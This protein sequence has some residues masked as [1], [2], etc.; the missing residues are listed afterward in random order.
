MYKTEVNLL[1]KICKTD[2]FNKLNSKLDNLID[3]NIIFNEY[4]D[5]LMI[6]R[7]SL[8]LNEPRINQFKYNQFYYG[9]VNLRQQLFSQFQLNTINQ[10]I[11]IS[12][13]LVQPYS[14]KGTYELVKDLDSELEAQ[15]YFLDNTEYSFLDVIVFSSLQKCRIWPKLY[16]DGKKSKKELPQLIDWYKVFMNTYKHEI[17]YQFDPNI[18]T[19]KYQKRLEI[20]KKEKRLDKKLIEA[21]QS[22]QYELIQSL[23][24]EGSDIESIEQQMYKKPAHIACELGDIEL[25]RFIDQFGCDWESLDNEEQTPIFY[26]VTSGNLEVVKFLIEEKKVNHQHKEFQDRTPFYLACFLG[27]MPI[28]EYLYEKG[29]NIN[30]PSKLKRCALSKACYLGHVEVVKFLV[31]KPETD[32]TMQDSKGR[33]GMHNAAWGIEGGKEGKRRGTLKLPDSPQSIEVL[34]DYGHPIDFQDFEG[35]TPLLSAA[36]SDARESLRV[37]IN[38]GANKNIR[39]FYGETPVFLAAKYGHTEI[40][41]TLIDE[42]NCDWEMRDIRNTTPCEIAAINQKYECFDILLN[43]EIQNNTVNVESFIKKI[44]DEYITHEEQVKI[45]ELYHSKVN[46]KDH[47]QDMENVISFLTYCTNPQ[48]MLRIQEIILDRLN[49]SHI[50]QFFINLVDNSKYE[51]AFQILETFQ[52]NHKSSDK[53]NSE[54]LF[55]PQEIYNFIVKGVNAS[56]EIIS[57]LLFKVN[58]D[59]INFTDDLTKNSFLHVFCEQRRMKIIVD[60]ITIIKEKSINPVYSFTSNIYLLNNTLF[61]TQDFV[62]KYLN[63]VNSQ[64]LNSLDICLLSKA[65]DIHLIIDNFIRSFLHEEPSY[66]YAIPNYDFEMISQRDTDHALISE[67]EE[68]AKKLQELIK[69]K[70][71]DLQYLNYYSFLDDLSVIDQQK[72]TVEDTSEQSQ[73][74]EKLYPNRK[75][76]FI[77]QMDSEELRI[78]K[79]EVEKNSIF[80]ID[81]EYYTENKDKNLG[82]VCTIQISTVNMDFMIDA[83]AL[84]SQLNELLNKSL[85]LN[86]NKI[87][88]LHGCENDIK[89][90]KNDFDIDIVNLFDTMFAEMIIKNKQQSYSLKNLSQD[91][92][93]VELDKSYQISDWRIRPLPIPMMNYARVD[94]FILLRLFPIMKEMLVSKNLLNQMNLKCLLFIIRQSNFKKTQQLQQSLQNN[95]K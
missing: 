70:S 21:V 72:A 69:S 49:P 89:W 57:K 66:H 26:A 83:M 87:K 13:I 30:E 6:E 46:I 1:N 29:V 93:G 10:T 25:C 77:N 90:L 33:T 79:E 15:A 14:S 85:F 76:Y 28:I 50:K 82:F 39:N 19:S 2:Y 41:K 68:E 45:F 75:L 8:L 43:L 94:S 18:V 4:C 78:L 3:Y 42:Y 58:S 40:L 44:N 88:I 74:I 17:E 62:R 81:L 84:R 23:I 7:Y 86:K 20:Q 54:I 9:E 63:A 12:N 34:H 65:N 32:I 71:G 22:K 80:G 53:Q 31:S 92:L 61:Y 91:Y 35:N 51:I 36:S 55:D 73:N 60:L 16:K 52:L 5:F 59:W 38:R 27:N 64:N 48:L 24:E 95:N 47:I 37:L 56:D 67:L 11:K